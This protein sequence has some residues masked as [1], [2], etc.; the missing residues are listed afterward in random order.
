[1]NSL[2]VVLSGA[3]VTAALLLPIRSARAQDA[4]SRVHG[5]VSAGL[6]IPLSD[7]SNAVQTGYIMN[8]FA[9]GTP[10]GW[11]MALRGEISYSSFSGKRGQ[12]GQNV[13]TLM[14]DGVLPVVAGGDSPYF[15]GG[16]GLHHVSSYFGFQ[17]ENDLGLN[18]GGGYQWNLGDM[19][20]FVELR[21]YYVA[22]TGAARQFMPLTFGVTF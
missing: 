17:S 21:Y 9:Q 4:E 14:V 2:R 1:M 8:G 5:G 12:V 19:R 16:V 7:L 11:P 20:Y 3:A 22:H 15:I 13:T 10:Q 6:N 18:F